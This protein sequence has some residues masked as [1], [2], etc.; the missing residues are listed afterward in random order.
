MSWLN[1]LIQSIRDLFPKVFMVFPDEGGVR[2]TFGRIVKTLKPGW[3]LYWAPVQ[4]VEKLCTTPQA[5]DLRPQSVL[6]SDDVDMVIG[7]AI[8]YK[9]T[10][11]RKAVLEVQDYDRSVQTLALGVIAEHIG[12][13]PSDK[14]EID[15]LRETMVT[16]IRE[17]AVGFGLKIMR[18]YIT[19]LGHCK[20][21]R[22]LG[23]VEAYKIEGGTE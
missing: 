10:D 16:K 12:H 23:E 11:A 21:L 19:D 4:H 1:N 7:G 6:T 14:L 3:Y 5:V 9:V 2:I 18:V 8:L 20:N 22:V 15:K 13:H 17:E